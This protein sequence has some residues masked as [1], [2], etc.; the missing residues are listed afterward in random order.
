MLIRWRTLITTKVV[1][2]NALMSAR[3]EDKN[4]A[5]VRRVTRTITSTVATCMV[6]NITTATVETKEL[7]L[8]LKLTQD[9][10][11]KAAQKAYDSDTMKVVAVQSVKYDE[12]L[13]GML[14]VDFLKYAQR[15]DADEV[16][17]EDENESDPEPDTPKKGKKK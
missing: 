5:R 4:M 2:R 12:A 11:L 14:E 17:D 9:E 16:E 3:K 6:C 10:A 8:S 15:L 13:Y 1:V 7:T